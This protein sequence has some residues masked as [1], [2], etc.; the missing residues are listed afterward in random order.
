MFLIGIHLCD[1]NTGV[2]KQKCFIMS[3]HGIININLRKKSVSKTNYKERKGLNNKYMLRHNL[4]TIAFF[5]ELDL[6]DFKTISKHYLQRISGCL[7]IIWPDQL[8]MITAFL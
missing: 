1:F 6:E 5:L 4:Y 8:S 3:L 2:V 7:I